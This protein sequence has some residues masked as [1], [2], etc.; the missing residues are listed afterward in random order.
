M[1]FIDFRLIAGRVDGDGWRS[2]YQRCA[3]ELRQVEGMAVLV[4]GRA[5]SGTRPLSASEVAEV[6]REFPEVYRGVAPV[7]LDASIECIAEFR[8]LGL[9]GI[10]ALSP[11][12]QA[13]RPDSDRFLP[14]WDA[15]ARAGL[16]V[17]LDM[18]FP[19]V[20]GVRGVEQ[21]V[22]AAFLEAGRPVPHLDAIAADFPELRIVTSSGWPFIRETLAVARH[23][24]N[25]AVGLWG[26]AEVGDDAVDHEAFT[27]QNSV[28][29][30]SFLFGSGAAMDVADSCDAVRRVSSRNFKPA[31]ERK[32]LR[33]NAQ[34][35][36]MIQE[37]TT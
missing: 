35:M 33:D 22:E 25:V 26:D 5:T 34:Q 32:I 30:D 6:V 11:V 36:L 24:S 29:P 1:R 9:S 16:F 28:M 3:D 23:K 27:Y 17:M 4:P 15:A 31:S 19:G 8:S 10:G 7:E 18:G 12:R 2:D 13:F 20:E 37:E 14:L 21:P